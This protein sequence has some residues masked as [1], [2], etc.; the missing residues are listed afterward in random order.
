MR[1]PLFPLETKFAEFG[2][3]YVNT[4]RESIKATKKNIALLEVS[5]EAGPEASTWLGLAIKTGFKITTQRSLINS[6][7]WQ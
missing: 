5:R 6:K 3:L 2:M 4:L 7:I 1:D